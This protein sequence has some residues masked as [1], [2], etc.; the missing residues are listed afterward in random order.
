[1]KEENGK[2]APCFEDAAVF[3]GQTSIGKKAG[4]ADETV[5]PG[6]GILI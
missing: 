4:R 3:L 2:Y 1:M 5:R 6:I